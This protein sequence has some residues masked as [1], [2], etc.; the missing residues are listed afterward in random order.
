MHHY[1]RVEKPLKTRTVCSY[2]A[3]KVR[4]S[5]ICPTKVST[6]MGDAMK[7]TDVQFLT[8][9]LSAPWLAQRMVKIIESGLSDHLVTPHFAHLL[10][11]SLRSLPD[12]YRWFVAKVRPCRSRFSQSIADLSSIPLT[13]W[14]DARDHHRQC[15]PC[16]SILWPARLT[17]RAVSQD[18]RN[19]VQMQKYKFV[20]EL[21]KLH[22]MVTK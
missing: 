15:S 22:N 17:P 6:Q 2:N 1:L 14:Q 21:D 11:P 3:P 18:A 20:G 4:T 12:Y 7:D 19:E 9:T 8:P 16:A 5:V 13:G 10:L